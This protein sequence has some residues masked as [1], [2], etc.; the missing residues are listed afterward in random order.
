M[1]VAIH[2]EQTKI[3]P[4]AA[5]RSLSKLRCFDAENMMSETVHKTRRQVGK[6]VRRPFHC[7]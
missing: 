3:F 1:D 7:V 6:G 5:K 2:R 4:N